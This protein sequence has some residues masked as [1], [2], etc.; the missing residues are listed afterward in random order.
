MSIA[1]KGEAGSWLEQFPWERRLWIQVPR[2]GKRNWSY[3]L[4]TVNWVHYL[5]K[6]KGRSS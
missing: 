5:V 6:E 3:Y 4:P 1:K 2:T